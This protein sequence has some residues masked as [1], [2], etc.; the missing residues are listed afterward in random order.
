[1]E[2]Q[3]G[4]QTHSPMISFLK[5][6]FIPLIIV[7]G[8]Y[9]LSTINYLLYHTLVEFSR[10]SLALFLLYFVWT[11]RKTIDN[12]YFFFLGII[13]PFIAILDLVHTLAFKGM[14]IIPGATT[15][16]P[17]QLWIA[18]R[19]ML[20][21]AFLVAPYYLWRQVQTGKSLNPYAVM[22]VAAVVTALIL[23]SLF[24]WRNF[25]RCYIEGQ[26]LTL[27]KILS[28]YIITLMIFI[29]MGLVETQRERFDPLVLRW[30]VLFLFFNA[31]AD[32]T[33]TSYINV[34]GLANFFGHVLLLAS[35]YFLA[36]AMVLINKIQ[37]RADPTA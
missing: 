32:L 34:Y 29:S 22:A 21:S 11:K 30:L 19:Y 15:D 10:I 31:A 35:L 23:A 27:F 33:F 36:K 16:L 12:D 8:L 17:T 2:G 4:L 25:P 7:A 18:S 13:L 6:L 14:N 9:L 24:Y 26:G 20:S 37:K 1:M 5:S 3:T 28:E